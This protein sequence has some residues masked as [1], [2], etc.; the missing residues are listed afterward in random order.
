ME[1]PVSSVLFEDLKPGM[2]LKSATGTLG[3]IL[4]L[5]PTDDNA[6]LCEWD[7]G[8]LSKFYHHDGQFVMLVTEE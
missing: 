5:D 8:Q 2:T 7:S 4:S 1:K 3:E 6:I